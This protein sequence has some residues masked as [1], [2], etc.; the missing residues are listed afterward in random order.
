MRNPRV[1]EQETQDDPTLSRR[2]VETVIEFLVEALGDERVA[3]DGIQLLFF[4]RSHIH[5][6]EN[7]GHERREA[8][9]EKTS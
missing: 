9:E 5:W 7:L 6:A 8:P 1:D 3:G 2:N 4:F